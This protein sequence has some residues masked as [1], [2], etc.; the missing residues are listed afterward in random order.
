M[1][2]MLWKNSGIV[3][4]GKVNLPNAAPER[5]K[6]FLVFNDSLIKENVFLIIL[7][8]FVGGKSNRK[9]K[10]YFFSLL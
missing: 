3:H 9:F 2:K 5:V 6:K 1:F 8:E 7:I 4:N 10:T